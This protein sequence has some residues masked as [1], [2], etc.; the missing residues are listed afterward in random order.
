[1]KNSIPILVLLSTFTLLAYQNSTAQCNNQIQYDE[2]DVAELGSDGKPVLSTLIP[3]SKVFPE[4]FFEI[5]YNASNIKYRILEFKHNKTKVF[6]DTWCFKK[7]WQDLSP[8]DISKISRTVNFVAASGDEISFFREFWWH[9]D[10]VDP[11]IYYAGHNIGY[12]VELINA[13]NNQRLALLDTISLLRQIPA[14]T[15]SLYAQHPIVGT[16]RYTIPKNILKGE[17]YLKVNI[18]QRDGDETTALYRIDSQGIDVA[19]RHENDPYWQGYALSVEKFN[20]KN[21]KILS[22]SSKLIE[23]ASEVKAG[24][25]FLITIDEQIDN[26]AILKITS[27]ATTTVAFSR[28]LNDVKSVSTMLSKPG[29][30][31]ISIILDNKVIAAKHILV[32]Q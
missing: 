29:P 21:N 27:S 19:N 22:S 20:V 8:E 15:P 24:S 13:E 4:Y 30:Y 17:M 25:P 10:K 12:S 11:N 6:L 1:M 31:L 18:Y 3:G 28:R 9:V 2:M 16:I 23:V 14:G 7:V 32:T 5:Q 26:R